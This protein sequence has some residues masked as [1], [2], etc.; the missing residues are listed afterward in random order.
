MLCLDDP[1]NKRLTRFAFPTSTLP[2]VQAPE[3]PQPL[4]V[5]LED[6]SRCSILIGGARGR[7]DGYSPSYG[8]NAG[9][10]PPIVVTTPGSGEG[11]DQTAPTWKAWVADLNEA[12]LGERVVTAIFAG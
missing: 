9:N 5:L 7:A 4:A 8:C 6:G 2:P 10:R 11:I 12:P 1:W 3:T